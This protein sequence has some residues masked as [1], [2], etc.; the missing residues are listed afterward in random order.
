MTRDDLA[1]LVDAWQGRRVL[2]V[3]DVML[4]EYLCGEVRRVS[5]EAPVP[6][7]EVRQRF[8]RPGGA[9]NVAA[10]IAALGGEA[11]LAGVVGDDSAADSLRQALADLGVDAA[12]L[13]VDESRPTSVKTRVMAH[14]Q[15]IV[16]IDAE[17]RRPVHECL[18]QSLGR[19]VTEQL[20]DVDACVLSDYGKGLVSVKLAQTCIRRAQVLG[21]P[22]VVDPKGTS[23]H[24]YRGATVVKP[25]LHEAAQV[26][27]QSID[28]DSDLLEAGRQLVGLVGGAAVLL[29]RGAAG[30]TLFRAERPPQHIA[31]ADR[32]VYD[33]TGAG[34]TVAGT[35]ALAL[36]AG[37]ALEDAAWIANH[38]AG[39]VVGKV[40][41]TTVAS[42]ELLA[43]AGAGEDGAAPGP[44]CQSGRLAGWQATASNRARRSPIRLS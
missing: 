3:G 41:T 21:K 14:N 34:D 44:V 30:M 33:V 10:N 32:A 8:C 9:A 26:L 5:P 6:V 23:Y 28:D 31:A 2:V 22:V 7:V 12:G 4:D 39:V 19:W 29:T 35:L 36:A 18:L 17:E 1:R 25:N 11:L 13:H 40:G 15:Q 42:E 20:P 24:K 38:A 43:S 16:R 37:A 27:Q